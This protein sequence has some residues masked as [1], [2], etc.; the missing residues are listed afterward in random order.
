MP[1]IGQDST[2]DPREVEAIVN[3][4]RR[5]GEAVGKETEGVV[6]M[7]HDEPSTVLFDYLS[8]GLTTLE[9]L[10]ATA[11]GLVDRGTAVVFSY[12]K[13]TVRLLSDEIAYSMA[14]S[15]LEITLDDGSTS[16]LNTRVTNIWRKADGEWRAVHEHSSV[17]IDV[18]SGTIVDQPV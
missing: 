3:T 13:V 10:R 15:H 7:F 1:D 16:S 2:G 18:A 12:P 6:E 9:E 5:A 11:Q 17:P 4:L 8:P 14:Y